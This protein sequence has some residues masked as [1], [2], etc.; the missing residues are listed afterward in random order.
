VNYT[1]S[2]QIK[3]CL[4]KQ[5]DGYCTDNDDSDNEIDVVKSATTFPF[6]DESDSDNESNVSLNFSASSN[7]SVNFDTDVL[8]ASSDD[9]NN[10]DALTNPLSQYESSFDVE[11]SDVHDYSML[12]TTN[13]LAISE[14]GEKSSGSSDDTNINTAHGHVSQDNHLFAAPNNCQESADK[15]SQI[16]QLYAAGISSGQIRQTDSVDPKGV[17]E[18]AAGLTNGNGGSSSPN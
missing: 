16:K 6:D 13:S 7:G 4:N 14:G 1:N 10:S 5:R 17:G 2:G 8:E 9:E 12:K 18:I 15:S 3:R 11:N